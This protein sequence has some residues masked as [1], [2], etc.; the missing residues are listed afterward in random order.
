MKNLKPLS[1]FFIFIL[2]LGFFSDCK[3]NKKEAIKKQDE[4]LGKLAINKSDFGKTKEG[5]S[6]EKFTLKNTNGVEVDIITYG[7]RITSLK[8]PNSK[9]VLEN[10]VLGFD[11]IEDYENDNPFFGALIGRYGNRIA[12]GKFSL[13]GKEYT[14]VKNNDEN[15][16]HGG[17][18]G[19]DRVIW[20]A[21]PIEGTKDSSLKLTYLSKD[22]EEGYPGNLNVTVIYTLTK[23]N[24]I[25]VSYE[26][27]SD[28]TTVVNLTQHAYFNLSADFSKEILD[29]EIVLNADAF[30][31]VDAT[32]IPTGEIRKV[33]GTPFDF[34]SAKK[35]AKEINSENLQLKLG[36]GYDHCWVLNGEKETMSFAASAYNEESGRFMEIFTEEPGIQLYTGNFLDGTLPMPN[37]GTYAHRTGFCL[38][39][40][41]FP[42]SPNQKDFPSTVLKP[43]GTYSTKTTFKFSTK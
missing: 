12:K 20:T 4:T 3:G 13:E 29:H 19:F 22:G 23:D 40:Q 35:I 39:T 8:V 18:I 1:Y 2:V 6:V 10:V 26:A 5:K 9:G 30:I 25:E 36:L 14:L 15:H 16:L 33:I 11:N 42:D 17:V 38:E 37:G 24:A 43:G 28:K 32:L 21:T 7:G 31:P 34:T 27:T 41:H